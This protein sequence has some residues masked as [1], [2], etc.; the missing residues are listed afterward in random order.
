MVA[1]IGSSSKL[2]KKKTLKKGIQFTLMIV[3]QSGTGRSTFINSL[4]GQQV[5]D[6]STTIPDPSDS[7]SEKELTLRTENV[8]LEDNEGVK[9]S[10]SIIDTPGFGDSIDNESSF[11]III[12]YIRHQYDEI[13]L[14]ESRIRRN[15]R[16][17]DGRVHCLLYFIVPTGHGL[18]EID[19][20]IM[21][22]LSGL[23]NVIPVISKADSLTKSELTLN[24]KLIMEDLKHYNI[25]IY[26]FP[27]DLDYDDEETIDANTALRALI[28]FAVVG[29]NDEITGPDGDLIRVRQYPWGTIDIEDPDQSD[30]ITLRS[31]L[32]ISH[33]QDLKEHTQEI[34]Y[35]K[36]RTDALSD[37]DKKNNSTIDL[38]YP[39]LKS[40]PSKL[41]FNINNQSSNNLNLS[42][43]NDSA[44]SAIS[45]VYASKEE[46]VRLEQE[47]LNL[48]EEKF[49]QDLLR[50]KQEL[51]EKE[52]ELRE[53]E[54]RL[55]RA[56]HFKTDQK[57]LTAENF[58]F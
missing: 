18:R 23:V 48:L 26:N 57:D 22:R 27:Y 47:R 42:P 44:A 19:V 58:S 8:E 31:A 5:V 46:A 11:S 14:E 43:I 50:R 55:E 3:G 16:F 34:L 4:C 56:Q 39:D 1:V 13:L 20:E 52:R 36:Y 15:P 17:K 49:K 6:T 33:L 29:S 10:L 54:E 53:M 30:F 12:D 45:D 51:L 24:K 41:S 25:P 37:K 35:E 9:V 2:R 32:L 40:N 38:S 21:K 28:P 7:S